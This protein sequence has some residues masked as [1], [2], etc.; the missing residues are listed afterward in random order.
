MCTGSDIDESSGDESD[1]NGDS[2]DDLEEEDEEEEEDEDEEDG[3]GGLYA[4]WHGYRGHVYLPC[5]HGFSR[6]EGCRYDRDYCYKR[7]G[8]DDGPRDDEFD[9]DEDED[10]DGEDSS[11]WSD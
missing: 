10:E 6:G 2:D 3:G 5:H 11:G 8:K 1:P 7:N 9:E 4:P